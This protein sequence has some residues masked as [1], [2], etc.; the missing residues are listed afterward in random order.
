M[1]LGSAPHLMCA[2]A[3]KIIN[4]LEHFLVKDSIYGPHDNLLSKITPTKGSD[5]TR[6]MTDISTSKLMLGNFLGEK[7]I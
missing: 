1:V 7:M 6:L 3:L 4:H 5:S 2:T